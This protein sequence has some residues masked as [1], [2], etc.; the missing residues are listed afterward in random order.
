[1]RISFSSVLNKETHNKK[2]IMKN[3]NKVIASA[4][5]Y[6]KT[7]KQLASREKEILT[8]KTLL[9]EKLIRIREGMNA[10][11]W[12]DSDKGLGG[13]VYSGNVNIYFVPASLK[14][15]YNILKREYSKE[16]KEISEKNNLTSLLYILN[17]FSGEKSKEM[18]ELI[19][20]WSQARNH[21]KV[22]LSCD[23]IRK[24]LKTFIEENEYLSEED[25]NI[26]HSLPITDRCTIEDFISGNKNPDILREGLEFY[27][28]SLDSDCKPVEVINSDTGFGFLLDE[29]NIKE[30]EEAVKAASLNYPLGLMTGGGLLT[31][32]PSLSEDKN[33]WKFL[34]VTSYH[35]TVVWSWQ[36]TMMEKGLLYQSKEISSIN[37]NLSDKM[38]SLATELIKIENTI[39]E[40]RNFELW[41]IKGDREKFVAV[42]YGEGSETESNA[43]QLW[44]TVALSLAN[45]FNVP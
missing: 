27:A 20:C 36:M 41:T 6:Y 39:G 34:T 18:E 31:A 19:D 22:S 32:N 37:K 17:S 9:A 44:S 29:M 21:F 23:E 16:L 4:L 8:E 35:G 33:L 10:G 13:G 2:V 24:R 14:A 43:V 7:W 3:F 1:V 5:P 12:R 15:I 38:I 45:P 25:I 11:D 42:P 28:L 40:M 30:M 26:I